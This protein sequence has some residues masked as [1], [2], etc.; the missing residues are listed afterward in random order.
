MKNLSIILLLILIL[1]F[2]V[3]SQNGFKDPVVKQLP[4][5]TTSIEIVDLGIVN[6]HT[7]ISIISEKEGKIVKSDKF[8]KFMTDATLEISAKVV[9]VILQ[10][11]KINNSELYNL[12]IEIDKK[13]AEI[14][15]EKKKFY[16]TKKE[17]IIGC[18][19]TNFYYTTLDIPVN[20]NKQRNRYY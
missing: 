1:P 16:F 8:K 11:G 19:I 12:K 4:L 20:S 6:L 5:I 18:K 14:I 13:I 10:K 9:E 7:N 17:V 15:S 3:F 2:S